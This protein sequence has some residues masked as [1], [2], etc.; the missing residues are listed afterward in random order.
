MRISSDKSKYTIYYYE[1]TKTIV[2]YDPMPM[3]VWLG[4]KKWLRNHRNRYE[5][6]NI[7][8]KTNGGIKWI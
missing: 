6:D 2:V 3:R 1:E 8:L 5:V 7:I 4:L